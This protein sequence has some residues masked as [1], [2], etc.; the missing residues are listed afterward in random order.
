M[1]FIDKLV[2]A[3]IALMP[4]P[5]VA[6][7]EVPWTT[8]SDSAELRQL[9]SGRALDGKYWK[10]YFRADGVMA[11]SRNDFP[12]V[13]GWNIT[14][15]GRLCFHVYQMPD[16]VIDCQTVQRTDGEPPQY[17]FASETSDFPI[18]FSEPDQDLIDA[19][20]NR[21]GPHAE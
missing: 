1:T 13:R 15:D 18:R 8:I 10:F 11:Y 21:A 7:A 9:V 12:S 16:R 5:V 3:V 20:S 4:M 14:P 2:L 6:Q 17:R 19:V